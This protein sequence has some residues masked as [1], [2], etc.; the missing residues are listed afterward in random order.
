MQFWNWRIETVCVLGFPLMT[1]KSL[2]SCFIVLCLSLHIYKTDE[3]SGLS[4][5]RDQWTHVKQSAMCVEL[6]K[7]APRALLFSGLCSLPGIQC[8]GTLAAVLC[9]GCVPPGVM[10]EGP[11]AAQRG[12]CKQTAPRC[13]WGVRHGVSEGWI[14]EG[15][16]IKNTSARKLAMGHVLPVIN[17]ELN[18]RSTP[19]LALGSVFSWLIHFHL[20]H[21]L[22][23]H[24]TWRIRLLQSV[25]STYNTLFESCLFP[26]KE[27]LNYPG[28]PP[29]TLH[30]CLL[31]LY[32]CR[33]S[34]SPNQVSEFFLSHSISEKQVIPGR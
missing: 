2:A 1:Y 11:T 27:F 6:G 18:N 10:G 22:H 5:G 16:P 25:Y 17:P 19:C 9:P 29:S 4:P 7:C 26:S 3:Y 20:P 13:L 23:L 30:P 28:S 12:R 24:W 33:A 15:H 31:L 21:S 14:L 8:N 32:L 34:L